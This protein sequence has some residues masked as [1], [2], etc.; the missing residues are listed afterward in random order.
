MKLDSWMTL[1]KLLGVP[2]TRGPEQQCIAVLAFTQLLAVWVLP[3]LM[4]CRCSPLT[5]ESYSLKAEKVE[6]LAAPRVVQ[7]LPASWE[8]Y[9]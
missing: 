2:C 9:G 7:M 4:L 6:M 3:L 1:P 8:G 5:G